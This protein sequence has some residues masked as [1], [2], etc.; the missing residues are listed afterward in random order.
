VTDRLALG[1]GGRAVRQIDQ[2]RRQRGL[3]PGDLLEQ[4][5]QERLD[6]EV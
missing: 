2:R 1:L 6:A 4:G 5:H 3:A